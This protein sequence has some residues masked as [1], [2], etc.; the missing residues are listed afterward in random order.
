MLDLSSESHLIQKNQLDFSV[1]SE[2]LWRRLFLFLLK[3]EMVIFFF[4][5]NLLGECRGGFAV[6][7]AEN[8]YLPC[9]F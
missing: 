7:G 6:K 5:K 4:L 2:Y 3:T 8:N 1:P 9:L